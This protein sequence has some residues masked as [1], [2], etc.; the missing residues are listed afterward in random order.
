VTTAAAGAAIAAL[1]IPFVPA[2]IPIIAAATAVLVGWR[3]T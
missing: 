3:R 1:L 2:G